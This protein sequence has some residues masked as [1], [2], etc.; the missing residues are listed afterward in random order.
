[1][2]GIVYFKDFTVPRRDWHWWRLIC[3]TKRG[4][5]YYLHTSGRVFVRYKNG[6]ER[7]L[8]PYLHK[9]KAAVKIEGKIYY[10]KHLVAAEVF[11]NYKK[12][13]PVIVNDGNQF[14]CDAYNISIYTKRELGKLTGGNSRNIKVII[15][16][17]TYKS[18]R[19]ASKVYFVSHQTISN[20]LK[21]KYKNTVIDHLI[22][23]GCAP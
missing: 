12:G 21:N 13:M 2:D 5:L 4:S 23:K 8:K 7:E 10:I 18:I 9:G 6:K 3:E 16:G 17:I 20:K 19:Q 1:M 22:I 15:N 11:S 14:N